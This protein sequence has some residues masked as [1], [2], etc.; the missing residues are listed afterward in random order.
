MA[1]HEGSTRTDRRRTDVFLAY[2]PENEAFV[3]A[4]ARRLQGDARISFWF[5]PWHSV[6]GEPI[7]EQMEDALLAAQACAVF[8]GGG[9]DVIAGWQNEQMRAAIQTRVEDQAGYRI[10]PALL[11]GAIPPLRRNLPLFLRRYEMV[12]FHSHDDEQ[13]FTRLLAGILGIPPIQIEGHIQAEARTA[14]IDLPSS[15]RFEHGHALVI[16]IANYPKISPLPATILNDARDLGSLLTDPRICGYPPSQVTALLDQEAT[17]AGIRTALAALAAH[18]GPNDTAIVFFSGHGVQATRDG[19][20]RQYI[21]PYDSDLANLEHTAIAG[22]EMTELLN[23][24]SAGRL[25]VLFD[26]CHS[27]GAGDPKGSLEL[28]SGLREEYYAALA[29]GK[30]RVVI[31]SSRPDEFSW[32]LPTMS[33]SVFT[34]YLLEGL[35]GAGRTLGDGYV[36]VFDVFRHVADRVPT[37]A[38]QHPIF[39]V[40]AMEEDFVVALATRRPNEA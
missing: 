15:G 17:G 38:S 13:A 26:S 7:Q 10:I 11:P 39:K 8:I 24:I 14:Q 30:G 27:G 40:A 22:D 28:A 36:R 6:P 25:L 5:A 31:A 18:T 33:N 9:A 34:H 3:E 12:E 29:Q 32:A 21:L 2:A 20:L 16:G 37:R 1:D 4:L 19:I 23:T 35:R